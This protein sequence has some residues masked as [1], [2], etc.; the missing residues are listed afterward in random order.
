[1][2]P[3]FYFNNISST[4]YIS[5]ETLPT[6]VRAAKDITKLE[7]EGRDGFLTQDL[8]SYKSTIKNVE[9]RIRNLDDIEFICN[10]LTGSGEAIF[11]NE[12]DKVYK[13]SIINQIEFTKIVR[14]FKKFIIIF[15]CQPYKYSLNNSIVTLKAVGTIYNGG[16]TISKPVIK[17]YGTGAITLTVNGIN[18]ILTNIV[19]YV[20]IDSDLVDCYKDTQLMNNN[21]LG[22]FPIFNVGNNFISWVGNVT[23]LEITPNWRFL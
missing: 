6:I 2:K 22:E 3:Y 17:L 14:E 16:S 11:S 20:T 18:V 13:V 9:C 19:D 4:D 12:P 8:G 10:W 15:D 21:M 23:K 1:M 7:V 5:I